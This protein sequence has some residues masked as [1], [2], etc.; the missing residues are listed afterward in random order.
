MAKLVEL[1]DNSLTD[2]NTCHSYINTY[3]HLFSSKKNENNN[4]LEIG[5]GEPKENKE[6][7]GSIKL[8]YDYF[9]NA[10]IYALDIVSIDDVWDGIK[11]NNRINLITSVDAYDTDFFTQ[12]F[13]YRPASNSITLL[14]LIS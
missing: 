9:L 12:T 4:I 1:I 3:E 14:I 2:K 11:N 10:N 6:N 13:L 5:I 7:G 8:W